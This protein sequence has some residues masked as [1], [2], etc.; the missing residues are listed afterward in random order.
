MWDLPGPGIEPVSP[1]LAVG[2]FTTAPPGKSFLFKGCI[3][4]HCMYIPHFVYPFIHWWTLELLLPLPIV[5]NAAMNMNV[6][7]TLQDSA[8]VSF[9]YNHRYGIDGSYGSSV[10]IFFE[11]PHTV[12]HC[13]CII[14]YSH[15]QCTRIPISPPP[16]QHLFSG[17]FLVV[18]ILI[19]MKYLSVFYCLILNYE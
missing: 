10:E 14:V 19:G 7:I 18:A 12:F 5:N 3:I 4:V 1:A 8:F 9:G 6:Q 17:V 2:F 11:E 16:H 15:Q 13:K